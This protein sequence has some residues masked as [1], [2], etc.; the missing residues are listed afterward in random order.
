[1]KIYAAQLQGSGTVEV[2]GGDGA[3]G[4]GSANPTNIIVPN[5]GGGGSGG[6]IL[7]SACRPA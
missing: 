2:K 7:S 1:M 6:V 3:H 5:N 4:P